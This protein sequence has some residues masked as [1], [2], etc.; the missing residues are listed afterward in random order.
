SSCASNGMDFIGPSTSDIAIALEGKSNGSRYAPASSSYNPVRD[1]GRLLESSRNSSQ[2]SF[3]ESDKR[4]LHSE[5]TN[6]HPELMPFAEFSLDSWNRLREHAL[7]IRRHE[8]ERDEYVRRLE[9][10]H[11][12]QDALTKREVASIKQNAEISIDRLARKVSAMRMRIAKKRLGACDITQAQDNKEMAFN[13]LNMDI[14]EKEEDCTESEAVMARLR[15][16]LRLLRE[17]LKHRRRQMIGDVID[18]FR[19]RTTEVPPSTITLSPKCGCTERHFIRSIH[20][21]WT[22]RLPGH[23]D[24]MLTAGFALLVQMLQLVSSITDS[25]LRY[26]L[27]LRANGAEIGTSD[28]VPLSLV[29]NA[30]N[31]ADRARVDAA[32]TLLLRN[33]AQLRSDC[34]VHTKRMERTLFVLDDITRVLARGEIGEMPAAF[35]RPWECAYSLAS[36]MQPPEDSQRSVVMLHRNLPSDEDDEPS[37]LSQGVEVEE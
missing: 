8:E 34:G 31:K 24:K 23:D 22:T 26:P 7:T 28:G 21:P 20:L 33:L 17:L 12:L 13:A 2:A 19:I 25:H 16:R 5:K 14:A 15:P 6:Q 35:A 30:R 18:I 10:D 36:L 27:A 3:K 4:S 29:S 32:T 37:F 11:S 9:E 1:N